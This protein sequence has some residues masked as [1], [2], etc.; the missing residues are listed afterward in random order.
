M[1]HKCEKCGYTTK[2][3]NNLTRHINKKIPCTKTNNDNTIP[4]N[5]DD[6][7][8]PQNVMDVPQNV[9]DV[10]QNVMD[11]PQNVMDVPQNVMDVPQS[12]TPEFNCFKCSKIF[13]R[14][15]NLERH[16][17]VCNNGKVSNICMICFKV[18]SSRQGRWEHNKNV[19]CTP[20]SPIQKVNTPTIINN[21]TTN[22]NTNNNNT[23]NTV[24]NNN[25]NSHNTIHNHVN[26]TN[27]FGSED[28]S[29]LSKDV[30]ILQKLR[31]FGKSGIYGLSKIIDDVHFNNDR[32]EN[33]T[34]IKPEEYGNGVMIMNDNKEWEFREFEDIRE[35]L[36]D[37]VIKYLKAYNTVKNN[38]GIK[39]VEEKERNI[40]K[41]IA[42][43]L[44]ALDG[45]IP[46]ELFEELEMDEDNVEDNEEEIRNKIRKFDKSTLRN[47]HNR[48]VTNYKKE[49]GN[50]IKK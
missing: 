46:R 30:S 32:P 15:D 11:V 2:R 34:L 8:L 41:N 10:P 1:V 43:E 5:M 47:I 38:L 42:Y 50:Y 19:K 36:I 17:R 23:N 14:K 37:T 20:P 26:V 39:L 44:M 40:I 22:N 35:T 31:L 25:I 33:N 6:T 12:M 7:V 28:L 21:N 4:S 48:T 45:F 24:N 16:L 49:N 9:M 18:F 29:Y 27:V 3:L 13:Q